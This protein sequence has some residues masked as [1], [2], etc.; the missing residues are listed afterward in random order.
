MRSDCIKIS[1]KKFF[2]AEIYGL[3]SDR[4]NERG[5][6]TA[7]SI[8]HRLAIEFQ[9]LELLDRNM[10]HVNQQ[11]I[12]KRD[13]IKPLTVCFCF[14]FFWGKNFFRH[15][16]LILFRVFSFM[17]SLNRKFYPKVILLK[18]R[19]CSWLVFKNAYKAWA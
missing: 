14:G 9:P 2:K 11:I 7:E 15:R 6:G 19:R 17:L 12:S 8:G 3:N 5:Q 18:E 13:G 10:F 16:S 1:N 4:D